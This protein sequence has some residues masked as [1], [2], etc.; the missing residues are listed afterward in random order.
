MTQS[1]C[2]KMFIVTDSIRMT[3]L[4]VQRVT[5]TGENNNNNK[6]TNKVRSQ[7][8]HMTTSAVVLYGVSLFVYIYIFSIPSG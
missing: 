5:N 1:I 7:H 2:A 4:P 8:K 3:L 6:K